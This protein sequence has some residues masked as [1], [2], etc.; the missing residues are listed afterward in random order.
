[1]LL[2]LNG[3]PGGTSMELEYT[4]GDA[5]GPTGP[6]TP[7]GVKT[8][9]YSW[10]VT[11][12][13]YGKSYWF[14]AR[15]RNWVGIWTNYCDVTAWSTKAGPPDN[16]RNIDCSSATLTWA[17]DTRGGLRYNIYDND[18]DTVIVGD[19]DGGATFTVETGL[20]PNVS[21][22]RYM[23][24]IRLGGSMIQYYA[25]N[26][27]EVST[28]SST[29]WENV[30]ALNIPTPEAG[31]YLVIA[32]MQGKASTSLGYFG[33]FRLVRDETRIISYSMDETDNYFHSFISSE[34]LSASGSDSYK[35]QLQIKSSTGSTY[36]TTAQNAAI[37]AIRF[38]T[39]NYHSVDNP[40]GDSVQ[41]NI[42]KNHSTITVT[43]VGSSDDYLI[44]HCSDYRSS[45]TGGAYTGNRL[46]EV[47]GT[48]EFT[49]SMR[50]QYNNINE[51]FSE[52]GFS[53]L[54]GISSDVTLA[55]Q[56]RSYSTS[57]L[58]YNNRSH[59]AALRLSDYM[60]AGY[61]DNAIYT[62]QTYN[63]A[64]GIPAATVTFN[65]TK[66]QNYLLMGSCAI[67]VASTSTSYR[68]V[69][70]LEHDDG[71]STTVLG[72]MAFYERDST[73]ERASF[74]AARQLFL[75][76][77]SHTVRV[78]CKNGGSATTHNVRCP[79]VIALPLEG[80]IEELT[81]KTNTVEACTMA[82]VPIIDNTSATFVYANANSI[83]A[84]VDANGNSPDTPIALEYARGDAD[85][86]TESFN[87]AGIQTFGYE[88][89][90]SGLTPDT[91]YWFRTRA[92]NW[93]NIWTG[94]SSLAVV[95][96]VTGVDASLN[97]PVALSYLSC[98][99]TTLTWSWT[100]TNTDP[101]ENGSDLYNADLDSI[102]I[103]DIAADGNSTV[104]S[105]L[106]PNNT[107]ARYIRAFISLGGEKK[108]SSLSSTVTG[109][110][111]S[112][113]PGKPVFSL[114]TTTSVKIDWAKNGNPPGWTVYEVAR[115]DG[116]PWGTVT[117]TTAQNFTDIGLVANASYWY[118]I[119]SVNLD[120]LPS[121]WGENAAFTTLPPGDP[122]VSIFS[123][124]VLVYGPTASPPVSFTCDQDAD[125]QI[126]LGG[127]GSPNNGTFLYSGSVTAGVPENQI[128]N[129]AADLI[130]DNT[131]LDIFVTC[132]DPGNTSKFGF[133]QCTIWDDHL[134]P[135]SNVTNPA[136]GM[137][138]A[139]IDVISGTALDTGGANVGLVELVLLDDTDGLYYNN[140]SNAFDSGSP[141]P[142]AV[143][144]SSES[145]GMNTSLI[146][147]TDTHTYKVASLATDTVGN[148][149]PYSANRS[150][151]IDASLPDLTIN[152]PPAA[153]TPVIGPTV[154]ANV[155]FQ[156]NE[157][158]DYFLRIGGNGSIGTG[159]AAGTGV[160]FADTPVNESVPATLFTDDAVERLHIIVRAHSNLAI[161]F[162]YRDIHDD[163]TAPASSVSTTLSGVMDPP[164]PI[165]S[166]TASD[167]M[168]GVA[169]VEIAIRDTNGLYFDPVSG[170]FKP[171]TT[172]V[173][174]AGDTIWTYDTIDVT[175]RNKDYTISIRVTDAVGNIETKDVG[176][177]TAVVPKT[178]GGFAGGG[179]GGG[180]CFLATACYSDCGLRI[181]DCG[182]KEYRIVSNSTGT[183][184]IS[185]ESF[186]KLETLRTF[187]DGVLSRYGWGR[188]FIRYYYRTSPALA[189]NIR[190]RPVAKT[191]TR[192]LIVTPAYLLAREALGES[193]LLRTL[194]FL[195]L[196]SMLVM[197]RR[198]KFAA[199]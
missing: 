113:V 78:M 166:G 199:R 5:D 41:S 19:I 195:A 128:F 88:W 157:D 176:T 100:D 115:S 109:I 15:A 73:V 94:Y 35:Y 146:F 8:S 45:M 104:E 191:F 24:A 190:S 66:S 174:A 118:R 54:K 37:I 151:T 158:C 137:F 39:G 74:A 97:A 114:I 181:A 178:G 34:V 6:F 168:A 159:I 98:S 70:W 89:D 139:T 153:P 198:R 30:C 187:R 117:S 107:Y 133:K 161:V 144:N 91:S 33:E 67:G 179:G 188:S 59:I 112:A 136:D 1:V 3:N 162:K 101:N 167:D 49:W 95:N 44:V 18:S 183:Y 40:T 152:S 123:A 62:E 13:D 32:T 130:P 186:R 170:S 171:G 61:A 92:R 63:S 65:V 145:W 23:R 38:P 121:A 184:Y 86:P 141:L 72:E 105:G 165:I 175:W 28:T 189:G 119:R 160:A 154:N 106:Q 43:P 25:E 7:L 124:P 82:A 180:G 194:A 150:F 138:L 76:A 111:L 129:R 71:G 10:N 51:R 55:S 56:Y 120:A 134:A 52:G 14:R 29:V 177:F 77:G 173:L 131:P 103:S 47:G 90:L 17:W 9:G 185:P 31:D 53:I 79:S 22:R 69:A 148:V 84:R 81:S 182:L 127:N 135:T 147:F 102:V 110:T 46:L 93:V 143:S 96:T 169:T 80:V 125:F 156:V 155:Q 192:W 126:Q 50:D 197:Y 122:V 172:W 42:Y 85:G 83:Y 58:C 20:S 21:Y 149:G 60:W 87:P 99:T 57:Y 132:Y 11:G 75:A 26:L 116:G 48:T 142:F 16:F 163:Q 27:P 2:G 164:P 196:L 108:Y 4:L 12:L 68:P 193:Y 64:A 140:A 36:I